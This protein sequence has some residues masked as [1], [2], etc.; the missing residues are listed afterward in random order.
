MVMTYRSLILL[1]LTQKQI[2]AL[3]LPASDT[4][5]WTENY[6]GFMQMLEKSCRNTGLC[7]SALMEVALQVATMEIM[8]EKKQSNVRDYDLYEFGV[9]TGK[10]IGQKLNYLNAAIGVKPHHVWAFDSFEGL[11]V[12]EDNPGSGYLDVRS[13][14]DSL[15]DWNATEKYVL[16]NIG[17]ENTTL[18]KGFYNESL[19][20]ELVERHHMRPAWWVNIDCDLYISTFQALDWMFKNKLMRPGTIVYYDDLQ[21]QTKERN[22]EVKA[23]REIT[24]KYNVV[25]KEKLRHNNLHDEIVTYLYEVISYAK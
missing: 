7:H 9:Y 5:A 11:P 3:K 21:T 12:T 4:D 8:V 16:E 18:I 15:R 13:I 23:H 2:L 1:L 17:F 19:N 6:N 25:W 22:A 14:H 20:V 24:A 10:G